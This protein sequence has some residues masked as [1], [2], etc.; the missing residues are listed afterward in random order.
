MCTF[1]NAYHAKSKLTTFTKSFI[2]DVS[3]G[4]E[5]AS[6][7]R[8][9]AQDMLSGI[10]IQQYKNLNKKSVVTSRKSKV[11]HLNIE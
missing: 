2:F 5:Y 8:T 3:K 4:S 1:S 7:M 6:D 11:F 10:A 9:R